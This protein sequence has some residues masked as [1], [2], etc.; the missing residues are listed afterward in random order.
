FINSGTGTRVVFGHSLGAVVSSYWLNQYAPDSGIDPADLSFVFIGNS[1]HPIGGALGPE[2]GSEWQNWFGTGI[3]APAD[4]PYT[5]TDI[6][7]QYDGW[8]DWPTG[9]FNLDAVFN[10]L[11]G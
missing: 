7:R 8:A 3:A 5:V 10:A 2:S 11:S 4:T 6:V 9:G 1:V